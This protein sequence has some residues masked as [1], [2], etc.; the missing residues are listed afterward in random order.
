MGFTR[1]ASQIT[2]AGKRMPSAS[3]MSRTCPRASLP[4]ISGIVTSI[5]IRS[6]QGRAKGLDRLAF[7]I[8][9][10]K[11][12]QHQAPVAHIIVGQ[13]SGMIRKL[14]AVAQSFLR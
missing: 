7:P 11:G 5:P 2:P 3:S 9:R 8:A 1:Q 14:F 10:K 12:L 13:P 6:I 4:S